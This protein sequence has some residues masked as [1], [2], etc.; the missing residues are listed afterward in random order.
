[1]LHISRSAHQKLLQKHGLTDPETEILE[2]FS[3]RT[4]AFLVDT[5]EEHQSEPPTEWFIVE[6]NRGILLKICFICKEDGVHIRTA[7][8]PNAEEIRIYEKYK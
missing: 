3:N 2:A 1:M 4:G 5:R 6:T 7:Y 8:S